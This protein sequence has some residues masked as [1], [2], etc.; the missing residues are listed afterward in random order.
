M[1]TQSLTTSLEPAQKDRSGFID[2]LRGISILLVVLYHGNNFFTIQSSGVSPLFPPPLVHILFQ[3]GYYGVT[4]F[5]VISGFLITRIS[6]ARYGTLRDIRPAHFYLLRFGRIAPCFCLTLLILLWLHAA[7]VR[8]FVYNTQKAS[9]PELLTYAL[10]FRYNLLFSKIGWSLLPW[11]ILWSLSV[12]EMFYLFFPVFCLILRNPRALLCGCLLLILAGPIARFTCANDFD[13]LYGYLSCFDLIAMGCATAIIQSTAT[14]QEAFRRLS[15][16]ELILGFVLVVW[17]LANTT[18]SDAIVMGPTVLG[19]GT[20]L[21]LVAMTA[22]EHRSSGFLSVLTRPLRFLGRRSYEIYLFHAIVLLLLVNGLKDLDLDLVSYSPVLLP[23]FVLLCAT[24]GELIG[25]VWSEPM[26]ALIRQ[27]Y[28]F[29]R[30]SP[31]C[32]APSSF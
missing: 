13:K 28:V 21:M 31:S 1:R 16:M 19:I 4:I 24:I 27:G 17:T 32:G 9:I 12:E 3:N 18:L 20:A 25:K 23:L 29:V 14:A 15:A 10:T 26:N 30:P 5:F 2:L 22:H 6:L 11:D 7:Q 8:D